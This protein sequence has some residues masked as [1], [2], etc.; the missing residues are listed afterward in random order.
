MEERTRGSFLRVPSTSVERGTLRLVECFTRDRRRYV[1]PP[2]DKKSPYFITSFFYSGHSM[3]RGTTQIKRHLTE[4]V[5]RLL[6]PEVELRK[7]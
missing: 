2:F 5:T 1:I 7:G 4:M 3:S 6:T